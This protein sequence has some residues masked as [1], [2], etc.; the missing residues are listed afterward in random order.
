M[1]TYD[2]KKE[3]ESPK[4]PNTL[5]EMKTFMEEWWQSEAWKREEYSHTL[6]PTGIRKDSDDENEMTNAVPV[7]TSANA[8]LHAIHSAAAVDELAPVVISLPVVVDQHAA[9]CLEEAVRSF[10]AMRSRCRSLRADIKF[11]HPLP[12]FRVARKQS[13]M[14]HRNNDYLEFDRGR[15]VACTEIVDYL[16]GKPLD[17]RGY[18]GPT[19]LIAFTS[20]HHFA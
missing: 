12:V 1:L 2:I 3:V 13:V 15:K 18:D 7:P 14:S 8:P 11:H 5:G 19:W 16:S 17:A 20:V 9:N 4:T 10:S 6:T